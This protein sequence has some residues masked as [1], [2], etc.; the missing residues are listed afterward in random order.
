MNENF[1]INLLRGLLSAFRTKNAAIFAVLVVIL[2][3]LLA[4]SEYLLGQQICTLGDCREVLQD[5]ARTIVQGIEGVIVFLLAVLNAPA[6]ERQ[7]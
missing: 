6:G 1:L 7:D 4:V 2:G 3:G 5:G